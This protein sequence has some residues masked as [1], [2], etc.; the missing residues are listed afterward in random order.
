MRRSE[1]VCDRPGFLGPPL[2]CGAMPCLKHNGMLSPFV[3]PKLPRSPF[4]CDAVKP[5]DPNEHE[6]LLV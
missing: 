1:D 5:K 4:Q 2:R 3:V 6:V